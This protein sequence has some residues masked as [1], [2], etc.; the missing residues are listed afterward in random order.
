MNKRILG[1]ALPNIITNIT[2]P[3]LGMVDMAIV[4]HLSSS[5]IGAITIGTSIFNLIYWNFG[6]LRMGTSGF[7]AQAF[8]ARRWD[9]VIATLIR[10]TSLALTIA[11]LLIVLQWPIS[12][13]A[14]I[15][16]EGSDEVMRMALT[17][18]FIR[19]WAAPATLGLY[20]IK[21]WFIGMQDS[22]TPMWIA[23]ALNVV[24][25][26]ASLLFVLVLH[27]DI[28][29]V[30]LGTVVANYSGLALALIFLSRRLHRDHYLSSLKI[31][32]STIKN[33][34]HWNEMRRFFKVNGDIFLRTICLSAVFTFITAASGRISDEVLAIDALLLQFFTLFSYI[35]DGFA[36]AGEALVGRYIG[37][38]QSR[39]LRL[40]VRLLLLWGL[41]LTAF[42]TLLY[43]LFS[44]QF[45]H[46]F[47]SDT[48]LIAAAGD[49][50]FW[51]LAIPVCGFAAFLFDGIF[52][53]ATA[54]RTMRNAMFVA[55]AAFFLI[56]FGF[57]ALVSNNYQ[58]TTHQWNNIL[59]IAFMVFLV[60][61]GLLQGLRVRKDIYSQTK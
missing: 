53:G 30:A 3:L 54:S 31:S 56:Y 37:A 50:L 19:I 52:I 42:F 26:I 55:T 7:T 48:T 2:V 36:Y 43:A 4:G 16:F 40:S 8:G 13:L 9:E 39:Q 10:A 47:T 35:M 41:I 46:I 14:L 20:A 34:L 57:K 51:V 61:R 24:N 25:I 38:H 60:L 18:F 59:W 27:W 5:H 33:A 28:A 15:I 1:L 58:L 21:G 49:Y 44:Q 23:I 45:L 11:L 29:G 17:Y 32:P 6:F 12:R 22:K